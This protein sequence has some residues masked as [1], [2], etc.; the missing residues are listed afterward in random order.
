MLGKRKKPRQSLREGVKSRNE[1]IRRSKRREG[2]V[3]IPIRR[4]GTNEDLVDIP[5]TYGGTAFRVSRETFIED[6][7]EQGINLSS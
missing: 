6:N 5:K 3:L 4:T 1:G 2:K 7:Q